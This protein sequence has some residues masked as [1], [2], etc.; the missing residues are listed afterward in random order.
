MSQWKNNA[1]ANAAVEWMART[2]QQGSGAANIAANNAFYANL[3]PNS[4]LAHGV[5]LDGMVV[6]QVAVTQES[7]TKPVAANLS[8]TGWVLERT[9]TGTV[10]TITITAAGSGF[11]NNDTINVSG[12]NALSNAV[13]KVTTNAT[14]NIVSLAVLTP[15]NLVGNGGL[16]FTPANG[17]AGTGETISITV[18][19][20]RVG[21]KTYEQLVAISSIANTNAIAL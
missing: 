3:T 4:I 11:T 1:N 7:F 15:G 6:Q 20:G 9:Y 5:V 19:G 10:G 14:G 13:L 8:G 18:A 2:I 16:T 17:S 21:R 12:A